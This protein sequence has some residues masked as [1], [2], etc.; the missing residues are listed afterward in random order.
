MHTRSD[1]ELLQ[2]LRSP[3]G[4]DGQE[5]D[6]NRFPAR[7]WL[8]VR[9]LM[10]AAEADGLA[11]DTADD[12]FCRPTAKHCWLS[13]TQVAS[14][15]PGFAMNVSQFLRGWEASGLAAAAALGSG[16]KIVHQ[17][18]AARRV[19]VTSDRTWQA[20]EQRDHGLS[21]SS[22]NKSTPALSRYAPGWHVDNGG[23]DGWHGHAHRLWVLLA[24]GASHDSVTPARNQTNVCLVSND[25]VDAC[26]TPRLRMAALASSEP[27]ALLYRRLE[28][29]PAL[30]VGDA[31]FYREEVLHRTQDERLDRLGMIVTIGVQLPEAMPPASEAARQ[32]IAASRASPTA[33][34]GG[35]DVASEKGGG[36]GGGS[37]GS[38]TIGISSTGD[39]STGGGSSGGKLSEKSLAALEELRCSDWAAAGMCQSPDADVSQFMRCECAHTCRTALRSDRTSV[40]DAVGSSNKE[41]SSSS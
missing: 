3:L 21:R 7:G 14:R 5:D 19:H 16:L 32:A 10:P 36:G 28:C 18:N 41:C 24:K 40:A 6:V 26:D 39:G 11:R 22:Q 4:C 33:E 15:L 31:V 23:A 17:P 20:M 34:A 25:Q 29:C 8:V 30:E 1:L 9:S 38:S 37:A 27:H 12:W 2:R 13:D 35:A